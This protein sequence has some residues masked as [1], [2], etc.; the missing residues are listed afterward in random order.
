MSPFTPKGARARWRIIFDILAELQPGEVLTYG[1]AAEAVDLDPEAGR[2]LLQ[3][4]VRRAGRENERVNRRAIEAV[5]T[6]G[7]RVVAAS[8]HERLARQY[9]SRSV[10]ALQSGQSKAVNV[11]L[12]ELSPEGREVIGAMALAFARQGDAIRALDVRQQRLDEALAATT[13]KADRTEDE[14]AALRVR[15]DA[16]ENRK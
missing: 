1:R 6:V 7:Y 4:A 15:L 8:E 16:L 14:V 13:L 10:V 9:Q 2:T 11:R 5:P 12:D 3:A